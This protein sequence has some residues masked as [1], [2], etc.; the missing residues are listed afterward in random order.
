MQDLADVGH[1]QVSLSLVFQFSITMSYM[2]SVPVVLLQNYDENRTELNG[3][4]AFIFL[5][6]TG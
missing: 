5:M 2:V 1:G 6:L 4:E 3:N